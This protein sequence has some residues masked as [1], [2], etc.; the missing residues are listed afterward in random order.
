M[1]RHGPLWAASRA[2]SRYA[3]VRSIYR[4][5]SS[6]CGLR[7]SSWSHDTR[8]SQGQKRTAS[9]L[10]QV[11]IQPDA[12]DADER[13]KVGPVERESLIPIGRLHDP[14]NVYRPCTEN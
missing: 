9:E 8:I 3:P 14:E 4:R 10:T 5:R 12:S 1:C 2:A 7:N 13:R 11:Y 6:Q